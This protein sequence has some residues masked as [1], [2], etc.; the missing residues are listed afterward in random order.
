MLQKTYIIV[1]LSL[2]D[3]QLYYKTYSL[4]I[5]SFIDHL[6]IMFVE[7]Q[8][9]VLIHRFFSA[10]LVLFFILWML[11]SPGSSIPNL[12]VKIELPMT[13][14][15]SSRIPFL[16]FHWTCYTFQGF[17]ST[18]STIKEEV[19]VV[20]HHTSIDHNDSGDH[21]WFYISVRIGFFLWVLDYSL[22]FSLLIPQLLPFSNTTNIIII[23]LQQ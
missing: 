18:S 9:L 22:L 19:K 16:T 6:V 13:R 21:G 20:V 10:S 17:L 15:T 4:D 23:Q 7:F 14:Y 5:H 11:S 8:A 2:A 12:K 1:V 3:V